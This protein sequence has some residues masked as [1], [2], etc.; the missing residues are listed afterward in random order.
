MP[1]ALA[2][3][4][5]TGCLQKAVQRGAGTVLRSM[6]GNAREVFKVLAEYQLDD[7]T[8]EGADFKL[9]LRLV[10]CS[11]LQQFDINPE[12]WIPRVTL[13]VLSIVFHCYRV[14]MVAWYA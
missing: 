1:Y 7:P 2:S 12:V 5:S 9:L 8:S 4:L 13:H 11:G 3:S 14:Q 6:V 10:R